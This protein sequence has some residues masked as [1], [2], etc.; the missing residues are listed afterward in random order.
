MPIVWAHASYSMLSLGIGL[1]PFYFWAALNL[2]LSNHRL[3]KSSFL[4]AGTYAVAALIAVFMDGYSFM[5]FAVGASL[6]C[7]YIIIAF[8]DRRKHMFLVGIPVHV[9]SFGL[10]YFFVRFVYR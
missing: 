1:L 3:P 9:L 7:A 10:A 4:Y 5:M 6:L 2:F 8:P